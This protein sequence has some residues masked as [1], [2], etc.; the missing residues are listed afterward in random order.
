MKLPNFFIIGAPKCGTTALAEYLRTHPQV[1]MSNPKEPVFFCDDYANIRYIE[2]EY[3]YLRL[4]KNADETCIAVGE[5]TSVYLSSSTAIANIHAINPEARI[6]VMLRNPVDLFVSWH[7]Q[8]LFSFYEDETNPEVAWDLQ[9]DRRRG[10][11]IPST[12]SQPELLDYS[13]MCRLGEQ[14]ERLLS[15]FPR[16]QVKFILLDD[17]QVS[18]AH[19]YHEILD[20]L[21]LRDDGRKDFPRVNEAKTVRFWMVAYLMARFARHPRSRIILRALKRLNIESIEWIRVLY[22]RN[23][24][25][26][27]APTTLQPEFRQKLVLAFRQDVSLLGKLIGRDLCM[28]N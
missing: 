23:A 9:E 4:F 22:R 8:V 15:V 6:V 10:K 1:F 21:G 17:L 20:F 13:R 25:R 7:S 14:V 2:S 11:H 26:R 18:A 24:V 5:A 27:S 12:C 16:E 19:V 3:D 28:W